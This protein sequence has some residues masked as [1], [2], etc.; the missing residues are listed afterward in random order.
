M[1]HI[2]QYFKP[3][4]VQ[5]ERNRELKYLTGRLK[6]HGAWSD[7]VAWTSA[8]DIRTEGSRAMLSADNTLHCVLGPENWNRMWKGVVYEIKCWGRTFYI[9]IGYRRSQT[10]GAKHKIS[11]P[12]E[13]SGA[14]YNFTWL[15]R[16]CK[17]EI[18]N[19]VTLSLSC[20][21]FLATVKQ[22]TL[23]RFLF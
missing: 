10:C 13:G 5:G 3:K 20:Q 12:L 22:L 11:S 17:F 15:M 18:A 1:N 8:P 19:L 16:K 6:D 23:R 2:F 4:R 14:V 9:A 21:W 7:N